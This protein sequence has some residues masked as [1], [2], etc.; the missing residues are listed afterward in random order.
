MPSPGSPKFPREQGNLRNLLIAHV[1]H[2][3]QV[4]GINGDLNSSARDPTILICISTQS[5]T[6]LQNTLLRVPAP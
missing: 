4:T 5:P 3:A 1:C 2:A 6:A